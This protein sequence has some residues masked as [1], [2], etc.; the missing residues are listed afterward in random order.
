[1]CG[2]G[3]YLVSS[4]AMFEEVC[5]GCDIDVLSSPASLI[6]FLKQVWS[7]WFGRPSSSLSCLGDVP[8]CRTLLS[9]TE[10]CP[11]FLPVPGSLDWWLIT[12][13]PHVSAAE[14]RWVFHMSFPPHFATKSF[15]VFVPLYFRAS[16]TSDFFS[17]FSKVLGNYSAGCS[18]LPCK[19]WCSMS[20]KHRS[21]PRDFPSFQNFPTKYRNMH[22]CA[23]CHIFPFAFPLYYTGNS[24]RWLINLLFVDSKQ[25]MSVTASYHG[26]PMNYDL[27]AAEQVLPFPQWV[28]T[29]VI[30]W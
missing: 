13:L 22:I 26:E 16:F 9:S 20:P 8:T 17:S 30:H 23:T 4:V 14:I 11:V 27:H 15:S 21:R 19:T 7:A 28:M 24:T 5:R 25:E 3:K 1:M 6:V 18:D 12:P 29:I 10:I 2:N